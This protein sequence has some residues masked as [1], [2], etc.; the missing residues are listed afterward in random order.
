MDRTIERS[1]DARP[2]S[3]GAIPR[4]EMRDRV[5][6]V[7]VALGAA[8]LDMLIAYSVGNQAGPSAF[9]S[10]YE[11]RFGQRDVAIAAIVP[12]DRP[13]LFAYA[14]WDHPAAHTWIDDV[15]VEPDLAVLASR[16]AEA[17]PSSARRVG[18]AGHAFFPMAF[19][20]AIKRSRPDTELVDA[21]RLL[22]DIGRVKSSA[23]IEVLRECAR[24]TDAG[25]RAFLSGVRA[26]ADTREVAIDVERA[27]VIAGGERLAFPVLIFSGS[28][29]EV[30]IGYPSERPLL[31]GEQVNLVCGAVHHAYKMDIGRATTAGE[32]DGP[33]LQ[34][35]GAAAEMFAAML[36]ATRPGVP[37]D[38]IASAALR[39]R[40]ERDK[41]EWRYRGGPP[42]YAGHGIGCWLDE[43]PSLRS[44]EGMLLQAGMVLILEARLGR[45]GGGGAHITEPVV[46][47][48]AGA[49]RLGSIPIACWPGA[50]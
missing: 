26:G 41:D 7:E 37:A 9:L 34:V 29:A 8:E 49:E 11:P 17:I 35:L 16:L 10:G 43:P 12:G 22:M 38:A 36:E 31:P 18:I 48:A 46:V 21:S 6:R 15:V 33:T 27:M 47:T 3:A 25:V 24:I 50:M 5:R 45:P 30:G 23:E 39:V 40:R 20:S 13:R 2:P 32:P 14:Y 42:G 1:E 4:D 44:G 28:Q 19:A